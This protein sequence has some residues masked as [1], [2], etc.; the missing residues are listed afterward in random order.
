MD[1]KI[2]VRFSG[3]GVKGAVRLKEGYATARAWQLCL[4][5]TERGVWASLSRYPAFLPSAFRVLCLMGES[6]GVTS[7]IKKAGG[8]Q[9]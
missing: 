7:P 3:G 9:E 1:C 2:V 8:V 5:G 4:G 6:W